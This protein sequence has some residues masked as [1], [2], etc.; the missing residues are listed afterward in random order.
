MHYAPRTI[1]LSTELFHPPIQPDPGPVQRVHNRL[2]QD[3]DP[4]FKSFA[5]TP[6]GAVLSNAVTRPGAVSQASFLADRFQ[7]REELGSQTVEEFATSVRNVADLVA[8]ET[9]NVQVFTAQQVTLRTLVN[10]R[11]FTDSREFLK[12]GMFG[13]QDQTADFG[14]EPQLFGIRMVFPAT[15]EQPCAYS[16]R[17]ESFSNDPRSV[18]LENQATYSPILVTRGL[19]PVERNVLDAYEFLVERALRFLGRFDSR[20]EAS[21]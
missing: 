3:G 9:G 7:F 19:E 18:F 20:Q 16:L 4:P 21:G 5:V 6:F 2:F 17:I 15:Q 10:P 8:Q 13:F 11:N 12:Q 14:R 1:A